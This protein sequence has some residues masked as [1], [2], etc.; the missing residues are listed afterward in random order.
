MWTWMGGYNT[1]R[2]NYGSYGQ[3]RVSNSSNQPRSRTYAIGWCD[4]TAGELWMFG[5]FSLDFQT[6]VYLNDLWRYNIAS[7]LWTWM[8]GSDVANAQNV[9]GQMGVANATNQPGS[10]GAASGWYDSDS[11]ELW[12]FGGASR[13]GSAGGASGDGAFLSVCA[14][15]ACAHHI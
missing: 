12:M 8:G 15:C 14:R 6:P 7:S 4:S 1:S 2:N 11:R 3:L 13:K 5:G 9:Y 10:R